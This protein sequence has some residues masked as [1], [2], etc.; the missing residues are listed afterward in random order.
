MNDDHY[1]IFRL[2]LSFSSYPSIS[3]SDLT[4]TVAAY[5]IL[6]TG[7]VEREA[8]RMVYSIRHTFFHVDN[9]P[10][11]GFFDFSGK[12]TLVWD[13]MN[14]SA[15]IV[16]FTFR[17]ILTANDVDHHFPSTTLSL[18]FPLRLPQS[19]TSTATVPVINPP[20][21]ILTPPSVHTPTSFSSPTSRPS[22]KF[23]LENA[24][25]DVLTS[26]DVT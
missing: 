16:C 3:I 8:E 10:G 23:A 13:L 17:Y 19:V 6:P 24:A 5:F 22:F 4:A 14:R 12:S 26:M 15:D 20:V 18:D 7:S 9:L 1:F 21:S 11:I 25:D 2:I